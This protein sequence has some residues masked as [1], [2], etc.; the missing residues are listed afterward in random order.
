MI[1][2]HSHILP[3]IDDG[4]KDID[5]TIEMLKMAKNTGTN[6]IVATPHFCRGYGELSYSEVKKMAEELEKLLKDEGINLKIHYGQ[7][8]YYSDQII[9]DYANG[10]IGTINSSKYMLIEL[11]MKSFYSDTL[12]ILYELKVKGIVPILAHPERY[13][14]IIDKPSTI[15]KFIDEGFLF[16]M[17]SGSI[18]GQFGNSVKKTAE[19]L[20]KNN[21]YNFIGSDAHN[22]TTRVPGISKGIELAKNISDIS[23]ELFLE[24]GRKLLINQDVEF[25]GEKIKEKKGLFSFFR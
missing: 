9:K 16:Q 15:N 3:G 7:E 5:M 2:I 10:I 25:I 14:P 22:N 21:I 19:I 11:P 4:S 12:E 13:R 24:S 17:N 18:E 6:H 20:L 8:V 23:E 1:D